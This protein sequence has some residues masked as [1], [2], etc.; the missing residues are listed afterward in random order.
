MAA[1]FFALVAYLILLSLV[2]SAALWLGGPDERRVTLSLLIAVAA[3]SFAAAFG[4][5]WRQLEV[6]VLVVDAVFFGVLLLIARRSR[7]FWPIWAAA[8]QLAGTLAH[9]PRNWEAGMSWQL[10]ASS[11]PFWVAPLLV[12]LVIG[13]VGEVQRQRRPLGAGSME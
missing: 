6:G 7:K 4:S 10:Y 5:G 8:S 11:Q 13:T 2:C 3:T 1:L 9:L 12:A